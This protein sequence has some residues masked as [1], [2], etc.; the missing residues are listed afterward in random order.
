M[1]N[2]HG[3]RGVI[4]FLGKGFELWPPSPLNEGHHPPGS[5]LL[6]LPSWKYEL[7]VLILWWLCSVDKT[8]DRKFTG[9]LGIRK[10]DKF[11]V[12]LMSSHVRKLLTN[13][14]YMWV[15]CDNQVDMLLWRMHDGTMHE[16]S[17]ADLV[18]TCELL[19]MW[20]L[21]GGGWIVYRPK[22][23]LNHNGS[24]GSNGNV[25]AP[26]KS[27]V[28]DS[29]GSFINVVNGTANGA[30]GTVLSAAAALILDDSCIV[31]HDLSKHAM[32]KV[33]VANSIPNLRTILR[34][35]GFSEVNVS[36]LGVHN[37]VSNE[38]IVWVDI[39]GIP[40]NVWSRETFSRIGKK[41]GETLDIEDNAD[42]SFGRKRLC[43]MTKQP[44]SIFESLKF[45]FKG[46]VLMV[47]SN[48]GS[49]SDVE[50]VSE[51][52]FEVNSPPHNNNQ[53]EMSRQHSEDPFKIYDILEKQT[54]GSAREV[55]PSLS[56]PPGFTPEIL[57]N[58]SDNVKGDDEFLP[59]VN[60]TVMNDFQVGSQ[61]ANGDTSAVKTGG[62][63]LGLL[64]D[65]IQDYVS[66][67]VDRWNGE[68]VIM[69]NFN[70]VRSKD[71][72]R[73]SCFNPSSSRAFDHFI[74]ST[75]LV[76]VKLEGYAFTWS[77]PSG[78]KMNH[79]SILLRE[80]P[81]DFGPIPFRFY[82]SWFN[83]E[84]F[85]DMK[86]KVKW[87]IEGDENSK[88]FHGMVNKKHSHL[89]IRGVF[90]KG[91]WVTDPSVVKQVFCKH[92]EARFKEPATQ[93]L[94][95]NVLFNKRLSDIQSSYLE[96]N[97]TQDEIRL[98]VW[99][100]VKYFFETGLFP[101]GCNSSFIA[102]ILKVA[103]AKL[104]NDFR[105]ISLVG[106]VYKVVTKVL[107]NQLSLVIAD[108]VS[109]TQSTFVANRQILDG[110]F[111]LNEILHWCK[112]KRKQAMFFKVDF[113]K[114]YDSVRWD[115]LLDV[116]EAFGFGQTWCKWNR[117]TLSS[118]KASILVNGSPSNEFSFHCGLKQGDPLSPF[119][120]I[121][122]MESLHL[123]FSRAVNE[124]I[125]KGVQLNGSINISHL[126]YADDVMFIGEWSD[127]NLKGIINILQCFFLASGLKINIHK[128]QVMGMGIPSNIVKQAAASLGCGVLLNQF[129]YLGVMIK[130][131]SIGGRL[132][133]LKSVL[134]ASPL[135]Y[136]SIF[137]V[138][139]GDGN[140]TRFW[141]D[142][143]NGDKPLKVVFPRL[144]LLETN[145]EIVVADKLKAALDQ[146]FRRPARNGHEQ[147]Q[148]EDLCT[149]MGLVSLSQSYDR[150]VC[151]M[152]GDG[153][154]QVS[155]VR[156]FLDNIFLPSHSEPT[157]WIK[158]IPIK[159]NVFAWRARRDYLPTGVNLNRRG[160]ILESYMCPLCHSMEEDI[161]H[162]LFRC[163][164]AKIIVRR[165]CRWWDLDWQDIQSFSD[166]FPWLS[167]VRLSVKLKN[168]LEGVFYVAWWYIWGLKNRS[169]FTETPPRRSV[170]FDD[171]VLYSF[172][173]CSSRFDGVF[174]G[175]F[176]GVRDKEV[177]PIGGRCIHGEK[178]LK[179]MRMVRE[180]G[181]MTYLIR[182]NMIKVEKH[183][184]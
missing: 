119:L 164:L 48:N 12:A 46:K 83:L 49:E 137:K 36:Y 123:S 95:L 20:K 59:G 145:K 77:H 131:L 26:R 88:F 178:G 112:R 7:W 67:L 122:I 167:L 146:S 133:L 82:H 4:S 74:Y 158:Y 141:L 102:L 170:I 172:T 157:R 115:Y 175:A 126:F 68:A 28:H 94:L 151:D 135:Y 144:F 79:R 106:C 104:V 152:S 124:G 182:K 128:I 121:L 109:D 53:D 25:S 161:N 55:S 37:F 113:A 97:V 11:N 132:T 41:W 136:M 44:S 2:G 155:V 154:Y 127:A 120:F 70:E 54:S 149:R 63:I 96:S 19:Y 101:K 174:D 93:R 173:W 27:K 168:M 183:V 90:D 65:M 47:V 87:A 153:V 129:R 108:L 18:T 130:T 166:W 8:G 163:D 15:L 180:V 140:G 103:D 184:D 171:I 148:L 66:S 92:F 6:L 9:G 22:A 85:D 30:S 142:K 156:N 29:G 23:P 114:A 16:F 40:L 24:L 64:E 13:K 39:K 75:G 84:G 72:R 45:I 50:G 71:E 125:F 138:P 56:H 169:I 100:C 81:S 160:V 80:V 139:K 62:T 89:A 143:W 134:G 91:K 10:L 60:V 110:P 1:A 116:L 107:A 33:K 42:A 99:S 43:I 105:P 3:L 147:H 111:I 73:G 14:E 181:R 52:M 98:A 177:V 69:G 57:V 78:D 159:I 76:D 38:R 58:Q 17:R 31:D 150:W 117:G 176:G 51:T 21:E 165:I 162:I 5:I 179:K 86:S 61:E 34:D 118:A 32:G 35:E